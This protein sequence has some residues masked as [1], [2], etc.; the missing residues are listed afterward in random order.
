MDKEFFRIIDVNLNRAREGIRVIEDS[1]RFILN[2]EK[3]FTKLRN[4]RH[5]LE[6]ISY[7]IYPKLIRSR[8]VQRDVGKNVKE[9][10]IS[11]MPSLIL[12]N[13]K[14]TQEALR[15][16]EE[17]SKIVSQNITPMFKRLRFEIYSLEKTVFDA[18]Q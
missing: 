3:T 16:L 17:Y 1:V 5:R 2:D 18:L 11:D 12:A 7:L 13:F 9:E 14:R 8:D 4:I 6:K 10:G 15:V